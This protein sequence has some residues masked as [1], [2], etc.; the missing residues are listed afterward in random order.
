MKGLSTEAIIFALVA[1]GVAVVVI[2]ILS[3]RIGPGLTEMS[4]EGCKQKMQS[5][6]ASFRST[7]NPAVFNEI[8]KTCADSLGVS[9][10]FKACVGGT[11][12][13]C[14]NLCDSV[15]IGVITSGEVG[16][17]KEISITPQG[18]GPS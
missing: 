7:G 5:A 1:L 14:K 15:E 4:K 2:F 6:C 8:P 17:Q 3:G 11:S 12:E 18:T 16:S 9:S 10:L 13:Q